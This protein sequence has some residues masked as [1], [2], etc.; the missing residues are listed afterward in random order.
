MLSLVYRPPNSSL[1][2]FKNSLK[3]VFDNI[4][5]NK[6]DLYLVGDFQIDVLSDCNWTQTHNHL[7]YKRTLNHLAKLAFLNDW[8]VLWVLICTVH[9][10]VCSYQ[11]RYA[12]QSG[13]PFNHL[14]LNI[15]SFG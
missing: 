15:A 9:L 4:R 5:R 3:P 7:V 1:K 2:E 8:A 11:V 13:Q 12:F 6:K 14:T 10:T